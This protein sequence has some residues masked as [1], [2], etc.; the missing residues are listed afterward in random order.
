MIN[1]TG[2]TYP[3]I[4]DYNSDIFHLFSEKN[5]GVTR[6]II[7]DKNGDIAFLTRLFERKEFD[8]MKEVID[9]LLHN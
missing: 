5:A 7:I 8:E 6:N 2:I 9:K 4:R 3:I 1:K